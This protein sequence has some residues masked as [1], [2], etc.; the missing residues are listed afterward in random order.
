MTLGTEQK[1]IIFIKIFYKNDDFLL[2]P[3]SHRFQPNLVQTV[4]NGQKIVIKKLQQNIY[5]NRKNCVQM[6]KHEVY[7]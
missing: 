2:R 6:Y 7:R 4:S 5:N 1:I 3:Q